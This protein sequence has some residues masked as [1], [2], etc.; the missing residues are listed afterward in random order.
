MVTLVT[1]GAGFIG[2]HL[3]E[4]LSKLGE[5]IIILDNF[6]I[7]SYNLPFLRKFE[8]ITI[9][10]GDITNQ[11][12]VND[13]VAKSSKI[14]H[15]AAMN[16]APRSIENPIK[17][18]E[19]NITGTLYILEAARK[20][21]IE[22]V[23]FASSSSV[24]G[25]SGDL[26]RKE[27]GKTCPS[28]PYAV[29]KLASEYYCDVFNYLYGLKVKILR[30]FAVYGPRQSSKVKYAAVI[31]IFIKNV[32]KGKPITV[33]GDGTQTRNFTFV[34]DNVKATIAAMESNKSTARILNIANQTEISI[35]QVIKYLEEISGRTIKT[36]YNDWRHGDIKRSPAYTEST[37]KILGFEAGT[38]IIEGLKLTYNWH[39]NNHNYFE[40]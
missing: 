40:V 9:I 21:N 38:S 24:Y 31:P 25:R 14:F 13:V 28:H 32:I 15:L 23:V 37:K 17:S 12:T 39:L 18:N 16:R 20:H 27:D 7:G 3:I 19:A 2:S 33:F 35:N 4:T 22:G 10:E 8:N 29:G 11:E 6:S 30:Y 36:N 5:E 34:K 1:G 26:P